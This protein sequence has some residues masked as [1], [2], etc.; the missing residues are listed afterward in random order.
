MCK[1]MCQK[2]VIIDSKILIHSI[3]EGKL[4]PWFHA[5]VCLLW[6]SVLSIYLGVPQGWSEKIIPFCVLI[7][8]LNIHH[9]YDREEEC[10]W[11]IEC[12]AFWF[13][14]Y[15]RMKTKLKSSYLVSVS[16]LSISSL[17]PVPVFDQL[18]GELR[19]MRK[20]RPAYPVRHL[21]IVLYLFLF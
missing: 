13:D 14:S 15:F 10:L 11:E 16:A 8:V 7:W 17:N 2:E 21:P 4:F 18:W 19:R 3:S 1:L 9:L 12:L 5:S 20:C 6:Q